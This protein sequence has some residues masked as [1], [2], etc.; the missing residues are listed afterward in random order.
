MW[1][2]FIEIP[3][4]QTITWYIILWYEYL[5]L[6][7]F[8]FQRR[9]GETIP[10]Y[11]GHGEILTGRGSGSHPVGNNKIHSSLQWPMH[12]VASSIRMQMQ[13]RCENC[14]SITALSDLHILARIS[15]CVRFTDLFIALPEQRGSLISM[16]QSL[17]FHSDVNQLPSNKL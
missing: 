7:Y 13:I 15:S 16:P 12:L 8:L 17:P 11:L 14:I 6:N 2:K 4:W 10:L 1:N 5:P 9:G 3:M